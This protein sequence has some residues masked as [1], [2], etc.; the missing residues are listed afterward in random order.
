MLGERLGL[1]A[2]QRRLT[3][4]PL[5]PPPLTPQPPLLRRLQLK[6]DAQSRLRQ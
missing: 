3:L 2:L 5:T 6:L 1:L 4:S